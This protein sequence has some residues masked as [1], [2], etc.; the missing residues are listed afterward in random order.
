M[1]LLTEQ[2]CIVVCEINIEIRGLEVDAFGIYDS[3][4]M[5]PKSHPI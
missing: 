3:L 5:D 2:L 1:V 4:L